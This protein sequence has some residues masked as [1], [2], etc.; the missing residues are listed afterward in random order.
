MPEPTPTHTIETRERKPF[1]KAAEENNDTVVI[2]EKSY[3]T[4]ERLPAVS[5]AND[6]ENPGVARAN[7]AVSVEKP[8]GDLEW[9]RKVDGYVCMRNLA[10]LWCI[11]RVLI[12]MMYSPLFSSTSSSGI[13]MAMG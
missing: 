4:S 1:L 12:L 13:V 8:E 3:I 11:A 5:L 2:A 10:S 9:A 6:I 7:A